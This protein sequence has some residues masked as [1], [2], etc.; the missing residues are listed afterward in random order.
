MKIGLRIALAGVG[1][2]AISLSSASALIYWVVTS[3]DRGAGFER[4]TRTL[5]A[6]L[7]GLVILGSALSLLFGLYLTKRALSPVQKLIQ[8]VETANE[9]SR[10]KVKNP[11]DDVGKIA[12]SLNELLDRIEKASVNQR[13][14]TADAG[15]EL[16]GPLT[17]IQLSIDTLR[18]REN[19]IEL[20]DISKEITRLTELCND[21]LDLSRVENQPITMAST[22]LLRLLNEQIKT[23]GERNSGA[24][25]FLD[26]SVER[27]I[28]CNH[29][30][31][32]M[33][34]RN[35]LENAI[36]HAKTQVEISSRVI[37]DELHIIFKDDGP[38]VP[39][40]QQSKIFERFYRLED[41]RTNGAGGTGL[42]LSVVSAV[43]SA[44][45][46][47]AIC[48]GNSGGEF[49]LLFKLEQ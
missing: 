28:V 1:M 34:I 7:L 27:F 24:E 4:T 38:G 19:S 41:V 39:F 20:Q 46:G 18:S 12:V 26:N 17:T 35:L 42:G 21:L 36:E 48:L 37:G 30:L 13:R 6:S 9:R 2:V 40:D 3:E 32:G 16:R 11:R 45:S 23:F 8:E 29:Q 5:L 47:S 44:H 25:I 49:H 33:A 15:H 43:M 14:F 31:M 10:I 22:S